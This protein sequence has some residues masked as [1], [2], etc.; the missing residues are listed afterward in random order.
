MGIT[1]KQR[2]RP[3]TP[4]ST[5]IGPFSVLSPLDGASLDLARLL[6]SGARSQRF[7]D[8]DK[9]KARA[10]KLGDG[11]EA[12]TMPSSPIWFVRRRMPRTAYD[13]SKAGATYTVLGAD[14]EVI[15]RF[16]TADAVPGLVRRARGVASV[17]DDRDGNRVLSGT[18]GDPATLTMVGSLL[19]GYERQHAVARNI[20]A[21][22][23]DS[24]NPGRALTLW[25]L[26]YDNAKNYLDPRDARAIAS[27]VIS[28]KSDVCVSVRIG[29]PA[30]GALP[31]YCAPTR[32]V[33]SPAA[34]GPTCWSEPAR[35]AAFT[36]PTQFSTA[37]PVPAPSQKSGMATPPSGL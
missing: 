15:A 8:E 6:P 13:P 37:T 2:Q 23:T 3:S 33:R 31:T 10:R 1:R 29:S 5:R 19:D 27:L 28:G 16:V 22:F 17:F 18:D 21:Y 35:N 32:N 24:Q 7:T 34:S 12:W 36:K 14:D 26:D 25:Q 11:W 9:A 30:A 4:R 20:V